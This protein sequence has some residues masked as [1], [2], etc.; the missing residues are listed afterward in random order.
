MLHDVMI[1]ELGCRVGRIAVGHADLPLAGGVTAERACLLAP[2]EV[3][4]VLRE[5]LEDT[6]EDLGRGSGVEGVFGV[7]Q[8]MFNTRLAVARTRQSVPPL[9]DVVP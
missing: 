8:P 3:D 1:D 5:N 7:E 2:H 6:A 9:R 4:G